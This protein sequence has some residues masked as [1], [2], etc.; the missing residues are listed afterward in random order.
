MV[1]PKRRLSVF[2]PSDDGDEEPRPPWHWV[3]FGT[4][5]IFAVW[6]PLAYAAEALKARLVLAF[7]GDV[8]SAGESAGA[9]AALSSA[10]RARLAVLVVGL[11]VVPL[12]T[13]AFAGG[14]LVGRWG[15]GAGVREAALAGLSTALIVGALACAASGLAAS[16]SAPLV[17]VVLATPMA[18]WGGR[19]G[20]VRRARTHGPDA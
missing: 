11:M 18:A 9:I 6:L 19:V 3:G 13:S 4:A 5:A 20:H 2:K 10:D 16:W 17:G 15:R 1:E 12:V 14:Y 7:V 8:R